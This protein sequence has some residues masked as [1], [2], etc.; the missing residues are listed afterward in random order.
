MVLPGQWDM[1]ILMLKEKNTKRGTCV[2]IEVLASLFAVV[3]GHSY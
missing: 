1:Q 2:H 3:V